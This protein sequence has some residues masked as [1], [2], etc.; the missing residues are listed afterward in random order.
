MARGTATTAE[1]GGVA[2][3]EIHNRNTRTKV[4]RVG[5]GGTLM[6]QQRCS[7]R[8]F[9]LSVGRTAGSAAMLR[10]ATAMGIAAAGSGCGASSAAGNAAVGGSVPP[11][12]VL[13][14]RPGDWPANIGA[15][16]TVIVLGAGIAGLTAALELG[17]LGFGCTVLEARPHAGGRNR[18]LRGGDR[19]EELDSTQDCQFDADAAMYFNAGPSRIS[20]HHEFLLGYCREFGVP[21]EPFI[22]VN[23]AALMHSPNH[24]ESAPQL[25]RQVHSDTR[26]RIAALLTTAINQNALDQEL[27]PSDRANLLSLL[28]IFGDLDAGGDYRGSARAGFP[29]QQRLGSRQRGEL[30]TPLALSEL[31][32][33][34]FWGLRQSFAEDLNQ[35]ASMLQ[36]VGG[37]DRIVDAMFPAVAADTQLGAEVTEIRKLSDGVRIVYSDASGT[38]NSVTADHCIVTI[39]ATVLRA[40]DNDFSAQHQAA[41]DGFQYTSAVRVAFQSRRFWEQEHNIYGGISWTDQDITQVWYP[42][43]GF[44]NERGIII[45]AYAFGGAA[46]DRLTA[47]SPAQRLNEVS[48]QVAALHP[49]FALEA[50]AGIAAAWQKVPFQLGAW[51]VSDPGILLSA[52]DRIVF[53]GEHL[54]LLNG[55][56]EGAILSAYA[57]IDQIVS[58]LS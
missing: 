52:D 29:G 4:W 39:P 42:N 27:S 53:A 58:R 14:P 47:L 54:S 41:L 13:S 50:T 55:W 30:L 9:L 21:L 8:D 33:D 37:M 18:T 32:A 49:Q 45:G 44:G 19:F 38:G 2:A 51:G 43:Y 25:S 28:R 20:H 11:N 36:P 23:S 46:G 12:N 57:A 16:S 31:L 26:G 40:I 48:N 34:G 56:Q 6:S 1:F 22:N 24:F 15:G 3:V 10:T 17:R 35:Q 7:R 5:E